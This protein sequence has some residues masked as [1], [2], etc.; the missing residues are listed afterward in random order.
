MLVL[1]GLCAQAADM[2]TKLAAVA[3]G[4]PVHLILAEGKEV[5]GK[6]VAQGESGI[7]VQVTER[8]A[9]AEREYGYK[10]IRGFRKT[11]QPMSA[12]R[13]VAVTLG[14]VMGVLTVLSV[15]IGG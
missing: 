3:P 2:R 12:G 4:T 6:L 10:E 13:T 5:R 14:V 11:G 1:L 8:G 9:V 15:A 7:R